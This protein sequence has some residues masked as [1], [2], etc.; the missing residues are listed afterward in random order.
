M[1]TRHLKTDRS[2]VAW[3]LGN[4]AGEPEARDSEG[5]GMTS[6]ARENE[7]AQNQLAETRTGWKK[8]RDAG[9]CYSGDGPS[10]S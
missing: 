8:I 5:N 1:G 9:D 6:E 4:V 3:L 2:L 7:Q 10:S